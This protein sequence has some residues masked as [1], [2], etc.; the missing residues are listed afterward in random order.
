MAATT[1]PKTAGAP[2]SGKGPLPRTPGRTA[3][4]VIGVPVCLAL[5]GVTA[6]SNLANF[7]EG[8]YPVSY[9]A[10]A[11]TR[12]LRLDVA[13]NVTIRPVP[14]GRATLTGTARYSF[15]RGAL[16]EH[17]GGGDTTVSYGCPVPVGD[18]ELDG[19]LTVPATV[20]A[21][22][23]SSD[24]GDAT[25]A[26]TT[27]GPVRL[28]TGNGNL[29]VSHASGP[30]A[31]NT[32]SGTIQVAAVR[33]ATLYASSGNG[34]IKAAGVTGATS[35]VL[36]TDSGNIDG[37]GI[38]TTAI[39]ASTGNGD[40][41]IAFT[42][43]PPRDVRVNTDSGN[44]VLLLPPGTAKYRVT[45]NTDSGTVTDSVPQSDASGNVISASTGNGNITISQQ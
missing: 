31:L 30:L 6:F 29:S 14:A 17:S 22:T 19:T 32:G 28:S 18:C 1:S 45:A 27:T 36:N 34:D 7:A 10:P 35:V 4:L 16:T 44:I 43:T 21:L 23:A 15:A 24:S 42:G 40:I 11:A 39:T 9:T 3:A 25:V 12:T 38:A 33:S 8:S 5:V 37:S 13:G 26:G 2:G 20:T 41:T